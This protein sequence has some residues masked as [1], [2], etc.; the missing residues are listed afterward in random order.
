MLQIQR[1]NKWLTQI[2][3]GVRSLPEVTLGDVTLSQVTQ[4]G[5]DSLHRTGNG[6]LRLSK[7]N[8]T[9]RLDLRVGFRLFAL[10]TSLH[11]NDTVMSAVLRARNSTLRISYTVFNKSLSG[12]CRVTLRRYRYEDLSEPEMVSS[13]AEYDGTDASEQLA[14]L[15]LSRITK[16]LLANRPKV[17]HVLQFF[18]CKP[19]VKL[20]YPGYLAHVLASTHPF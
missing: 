4:L 11:F 12:S 10:A 20:E 19:R 1:G 16:S 18:V 2:G 3:L 8:S 15:V 9:A 14:S 13:M 17:E 5:L 6:T 7:D